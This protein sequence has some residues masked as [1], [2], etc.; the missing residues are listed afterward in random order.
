MIIQN[1]LGSTTPHHD[2]STNVFLI[3]HME[4]NSVFDVCLN[5]N[6]Q[7]SS[8]SW[9]DPNVC[10]LYPTNKSHCWY[11]SQLVYTQWFPILSPLSPLYEFLWRWLENPKLNCWDWANLAFVPK[12]PFFGILHFQTYHGVYEI[13]R[14]ATICICKKGSQKSWLGSAFLVSGES[15][16]QR[17]TRPRHL[18]TETIS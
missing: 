16:F 7:I 6:G 13:C 2:Q 8:F 1:N 14:R 15:R 11:S 3:A 17:L 18:R 9:L 5:D 12:S 4:I 10:L